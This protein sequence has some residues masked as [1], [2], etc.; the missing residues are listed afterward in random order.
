MQP[1][2]KHRLSVWSSRLAGP[3][4]AVCLWHLGDGGWYHNLISDAKKMKLIL[5][6]WHSAAAVVQRDD[7]KRKIEKQD[8]T[9]A[10][11]LC[12]SSYWNMILQDCFNCRN[13]WCRVHDKKETEEMRASDSHDLVESGHEATTPIK[14]L[15]YLTKWFEAE[16]LSVAAN[17]E[18]HFTFGNSENKTPSS[19]ASD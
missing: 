10:K 16:D 18:T 6:A 7:S 1:L 5:S 19:S 2:C 13:S 17:A 8:C 9:A 11:R 4:F 12:L 3:G 14:L 15:K